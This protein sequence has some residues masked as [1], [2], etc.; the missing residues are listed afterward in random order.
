M[1]PAPDLVQFF[2]ALAD[3][4][5]LR[6]VGLLARESYSGEVLAELLEIKPATVSHH[7]A[8][9]AEAGLVTARMQGHSKLYSLR[10]DVV[11]A[12]SNSLRA[13]DASPQAAPRTAGDLEGA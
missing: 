4:N 8:R 9:L 5:R 13:R 10:L 1:Q 7:L 11:H 3:E 6:I 12:M 2:K